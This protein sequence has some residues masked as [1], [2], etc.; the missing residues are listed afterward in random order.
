[1]AK[2]LPKQVYIRWHEEVN[3]PYMQVETCADMLLTV[4][5]IGE[6]ITAGI[7][8]LKKTVTLTNTTKI[9]PVVL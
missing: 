2:N 9:Q 6:Q 8:E 5:D 4:E 3:E 7:Y 1:M